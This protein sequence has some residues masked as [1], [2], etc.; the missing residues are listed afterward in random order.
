MQAPDVLLLSSGSEAQ[1]ASQNPVIAIGSVELAGV[2]IN[3]W[4]KVPCRY[5]SIL[6]TAFQ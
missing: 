3:P 6:L 5:L 2:S 4:C 1:S